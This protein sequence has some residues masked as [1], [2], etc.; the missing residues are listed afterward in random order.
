MWPRTGWRRA[1][2]YLSHRLRRLRGTPNSI[3]V[4]F[5]WGVAIS[6]TPLIG[7]HFLLAAL[8]AWLTGG[9]L[10]ASA[11]GTAF[12][13]PW[14]FPLIWLI[15][16]KLGSYLMGL[17][18]SAALPQP[19]TMTYIFHSPGSV[20]W[21]MLTGSVVLGTVAWLASFWIIRR[22]VDRYRRMRRARIRRRRAGPD[23][24]G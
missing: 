16:F 8:C 10:F 24:Q 22:A 2:T 15:S 20:F 12:G 17:N 14:T 1:A 3:A 6:F 4:G 7:F 5:A 18:G 21:P 13:N 9:S 23:G 11:V 19:L